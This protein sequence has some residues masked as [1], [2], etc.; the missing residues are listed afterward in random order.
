MKAS[1]KFSLLSATA[2]A[3]VIAMLPGHSRLLAQNRLTWSIVGQN[4][5][6][7]ALGLAIRKL[8]VSGTF[9]QAPAHPDDET[10]ALFALFTHGMGLRSI[11]LQNNRGDG[12]QNEIGPELF[13]EI[14]VLRTAELLSAHRIDGA[15][16]YFTRAI[17]YGYSFDPQEV[18]QKWGREDIVG[19]YVRLLRTLRPDVVVT[20]NIQGG[21]GDRAHEAT[22]VLFREAYTAAGDATKYPDQLKEGLRPWQPKKLYFA[23][24]PPPPGAQGGRGGNAGGRGGNTGRG[25]N[26]GA[27]TNG[28]GGGGANTPDT[29]PQQAA[30]QA[31]QPAPAA[32]A[33][34]AVKLTP[35]NT[36][37][38][39]PLLGRTYAEIGTDARS[40][41]KC[42]GM[43]GLPAL[44][45]FAAG[46][47]GGPGAGAGYQLIESTIP[48]Q[49]D[50]TE[51]SL[52]DG[53]DIRLE[54]IAQYAG[55][56]PPAA[57]TNSIR[58]IAA[59]AAQ[60]KKAFDSG[61]DAAAAAPIEAGLAAIRN[62]RSQLNG[63]GLDEGARYEID[64]R[65]RNKEKDYED[66]VIAAHGLSFD[67]V[68]DDGLVVAGQP[69]KLSLLA[70]NRGASDVSVASVA[71]T[72]FDAP[73]ACKPGDLK[74]DAVFTCTSDAH[75][76][77]D[78]R[79]TT[80]Y[81]HDN[82]WK[83]PENQA[84]QI[85]DP[86]VE[87]GAPFA[88]TP[89]RVAFRVKAGSVE[90][91]R[92]V[93]VEFRYVKDIYLGD[94]RMELNV[95]PALSVTVTPGLAVLPASAGSPARREVHVTVTNGSK[96]AAQSSVTL[97]LPDGWKATPAS[98]PVK[99]VHEDETLSAK[100]EV[101]PPARAKV[102]QYTLS[103]VVTSPEFPN[104]KFTEG[105]QVIEYPHIQRRQVMK[106][107]EA[108]LK[109]VDV[110]VTP[111]VNVGYIVGVGDQVPA[112]LEQL[113]AKVNEI[114]P[115]ELAWG[116]LSKHDVIITGV[117]AYEQRSD[118]R[119]YNRRLLEYVERGGTAIIQY[120]KTEFNQSDYGPYPAK[121]SNNRVS[122]ESVPVKVLAPADPVF[123]Y[124]NKI[125]PTAWSGWVQERGL[126]FLGEKDPKYIDL[127][128]MTDSFKDNPGEKL[129]SMVEAKYGRGRWIYL[130]LALWR[131]LPAGTDGA[132]QL[133]ANLISPQKTT[134]TAIARRDVQ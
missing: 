118:L 128:S 83:H 37:T 80:P 93:P 74:K 133:L 75:V 121:V 101:T 40:N 59:D 28:R 7:V 42:Q 45:G 30:Q 94:K 117:R 51:T 120:N 26:N 61:D 84:I 24:P 52:L 108:T 132:Y 76:P 123:N 36:N 87:F 92:E 98:V 102:G 9:M 64:F 112:A 54:A 6:H 49:K 15:E 41:H 14:A 39:D 127:V 115:D 110:K 2:A 131:Q 66:A 105:Y 13:R 62:L 77:K 31:A 23:A 125:G 63:M 53:V 20:M 25:G 126:Y 58:A 38:Y 57:L 22:T 73:A 69:V 124:P 17:D 129:G 95:V 116:D 122:D 10:N 21:G 4:S 91:T 5:G 19:D 109:V 8:G 65:L 86:G 48:G 134:A 18:I 67:A 35:V 78:A 107:A 82:Y 111:N 90:I 50:Q 79:P 88:P 60:A 27:G 103:A 114:G 85:F 70:V 16:Q 47:G 55:A 81:F 99:F 72:G 34:P 97:N 3:I 104:E 56:N 12:G 46:R 43:T 130:G 29:P 106:P 68:A 119:A 1:W 113:G 32:P 89:F 100:F 44:P 11:D 71:I 33:R 96:G